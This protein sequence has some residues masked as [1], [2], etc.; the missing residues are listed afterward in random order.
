MDLS[1]TESIS[2]CSQKCTRTTKPLALGFHDSFCPHTLFSV[3]VY[4]H[5]K[6]IQIKAKCEFKAH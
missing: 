4:P 5:L 2:T 1:F 6:I 3:R